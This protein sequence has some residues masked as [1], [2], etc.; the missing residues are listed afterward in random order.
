MLYEH[1][2]SYYISASFPLIA[3][4]GI[5]LTPNPMDMLMFFRIITLT[6]IHCLLLTFATPTP[7]SPNLLPP[8]P[9]LPHNLTSEP[10]I[11]CDRSATGRLQSIEQVRECKSAVAF[12]PLPL[13]E[14][15]IFGPR[16]SLPWYR[17]PITSTHSTR[18]EV[19]VDILGAFSSD[20]ASWE[21]VREAAWDVIYTCL[22][23]KRRV[24]YARVGERYG[25]KVGIVYYFG[26]ASEE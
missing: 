7:S 10:R 3:D 17:T 9:T 19:T 20:K 22:N 12:L 21:K 15:H 8:S 2:T 11:Y 6:Y 23:D 25:I 18:C 26:D 1:S 13:D 24:G 14:I 4:L 16:Q 5:S